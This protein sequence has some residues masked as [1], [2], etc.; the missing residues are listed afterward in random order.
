MDDD[1]KKL[2][3]ALRAE[4]AAAHVETRRHFDVA[5]ESAKDDIRLVAERVEQT[6]RD[7]ATTAVA[8]D[9]K[10]ESTAAE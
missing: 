3:D 2:L 9:Q 5:L 4:N 10:I 6:R 1:L 8:L 7:L